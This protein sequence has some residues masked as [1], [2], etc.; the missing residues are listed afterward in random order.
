MVDGSKQR[1]YNGYDNS[2]GLLPTV[3]TDSIFLTGVV[4]AHEKQAIAILYITN[5]FLHADNDEKI[6]MLLRV[7]LD[8]MMVQVDPIMY[9]MY[10]TYS[11][12]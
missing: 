9:C 4:D 5:A 10:V 11:P 1:M 7:K 8:E 3:L 12:D 2:D 6:L